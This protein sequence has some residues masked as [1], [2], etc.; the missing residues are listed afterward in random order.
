[1]GPGYM[2][3]ARTGSLEAISYG[4]STLLS[5]DTGGGTV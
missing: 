3:S 2:L 5:L 1:M 4:V